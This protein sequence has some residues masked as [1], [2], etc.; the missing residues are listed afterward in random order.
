MENLIPVIAISV[1]IISAVWGHALWLSGQFK[2]VYKAI[3]QKFDKILDS[4]SEKLEYHE[5]HDDQRFGHI[6]DSIWEVRLQQ[7]LQNGNLVGKKKAE[8]RTGGPENSIRS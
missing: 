4:L 7:A 2:G 3:D 6:S 1:T 8:I 5:R